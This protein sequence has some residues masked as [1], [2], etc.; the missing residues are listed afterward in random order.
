MKILLSPWLL[1]LILLFALADMCG[2]VL[3]VFSAVLW[4]ELSHAWVAMK[5]G[6]KVREIELLPFGGVA[7]IEGLGIVSP[8]QEMMIAAAGPAVSLVLAA[9]SY[10]LMT[11]GGMWADVWEF[12]Y[13]TN[14]MLA[15]FNLL[16]GL[17]LDGGRILRAYLGLYMDYGKATLIAV[18]I[19]KW[20][21]VCLVIHVIYEY[22]TT[23]TI[24]L[25]FVVAALFLYITA[26]CE[27]KV[28]SFRTLRILS[29]KKAELVGRGAMLTTYFTVVH[30]VL[31]K[32]LIK[33]FAADQYYIV[34]IVDE[35]C[36][37][38]ATVTETKIWEA[39]PQKGL[40]ATIGEL[41]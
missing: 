15:L 40:Y 14:M 31:L 22:M 18:I 20:I 9:T 21:S 5:F 1:L 4:H 19:S 3:L 23:S 28:A 24:N 32:D 8:G 29:Q 10:L 6:L 2:K 17:P 16:P 36:K 30:H 26:D 25:T 7:R 41:I 39:L 13:R 12:Y 35:E 11:Y 37:L 33:L 27:V 34:R 38:Y